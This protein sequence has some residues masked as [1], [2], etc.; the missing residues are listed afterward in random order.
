MTSEHGF[1]GLLE[2]STCANRHSS[3]LHFLLHGKIGGVDPLYQTHYFNGGESP[4]LRLLCKIASQKRADQ[5]NQQK[6]KKLRGRFFCFCLI[7]SLKYIKLACSLSNMDGWNTSK[8]Y[9]GVWAYN[10]TGVCCLPSGRV[11]NHK[12]WVVLGGFSM[13]AIFGWHFG[14]PGVLYGF[15]ILKPFQHITG[16][17]T[18]FW[19]TRARKC[20]IK[21]QLRL[22]F[23][24]VSFLVFLGWYFLLNKL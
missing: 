1:V 12:S 8:S 17:T 23:N 9:L 6:M 11:E 22:H 10:F 3:I 19:G 16:R 20:G 21:R 24:C 7:P 14:A 18:R 15:V 4:F 13:P 5:Q 2:K